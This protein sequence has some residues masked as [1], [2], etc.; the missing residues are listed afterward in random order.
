MEKV[1]KQFIPTELGLTVNKILTSYFE[2]FFNVK[3]TAEMEESLDEIEY[4]KKDLISVLTTYYNALES[5]IKKLDIKKLKDQLIEK[6]DIIC[7]KC[8]AKMVIRWGK[9]GQFLA[10]S[11]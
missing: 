6:T 3:F 7:E 5:L 8:G 9:N 11:N 2:S 1:K 10:C 4:G